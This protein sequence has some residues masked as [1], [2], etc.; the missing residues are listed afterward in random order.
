[1]R[2]LIGVVLLATIAG[3]ARTRTVS[4]T[5]TT[6]RPAGSGTKVEG[7]TLP[8]D[9]HVTIVRPGAAPVVYTTEQIAALSNR[10][11]RRGPGPTLAAV[12]R[13]AASDQ[14]GH[15][16]RMEGAT[17]DVVEVDIEKVLDTEEDYELFLTPRR[18]VKIDCPQGTV[19]HIVTITVF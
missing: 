6:S 19:R 11:G 15:R 2:G 13:S 7:G 12:L 9:Y 16:L 8:S 14:R 3:C 18:T 17:G 4:T 1:M 5:T 10:G